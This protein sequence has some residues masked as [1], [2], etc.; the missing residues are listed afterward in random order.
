MSTLLGGNLNKQEH[1]SGRQFRP[2]TNGEAPSFQA[3]CEIEQSTG[4]IT[5][6]TETD[7]MFAERYEYSYD[8][9]GRL[10]GVNLNGQRHEVY[11]YDR[12]GRR[13][14]RLT[15]KTDTP[16]YYFYDQLGRLESVNQMTLFKYDANGNTV[17][18]NG[19]WYLQTDLLRA[20]ETCYKYG[21]NT[22]LDEAKL[23]GNIALRYEYDQKSAN[24][25]G[26]SRRFRNGELTHEY[27]WL[28]SAEGFPLLSIC[29]DISQGLEF[30]LI[31]GKRHYPERITLAR[32]PGI[33]RALDKALF[34]NGQASI[35]LRCG[36][37]QV[38]TLKRLY[39]QGREI[40]RI[41]YDSFGEV[42]NETLPMLYLPLGFAAGLTDPDTLLV[43]FG[44]RDYDPST[45]R[46]L[47]MDPAK[48]R[49]GD[50]DLYEYCMDDPVNLV[51]PKG[52]MGCAARPTVEEARQMEEQAA[53]EQGLGQR[54]AVAPRQEQPAERRWVMNQR[55]G[56]LRDPD[57]NVLESGYSGAPDYVNNP[58]AE[59][60]R[61]LGPIPRGRYR[62]GETFNSARTGPNSIRLAPEGHNA[63]DRTGLQIHGENPR[64]PPRSFSEGCP[65]YGPATR[66]R[67]TQS[68][69]QG[70]QW[71]D[72]V[73]D[74]DW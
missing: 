63:H 42:L 18:R 57:G 65:I 22:L 23:P 35:T 39:L 28:R 70:V 2:G 25:Q 66:R 9:K 11:K 30:Q 67:I 62:I 27:T 53:R 59:N 72:V 68:Q 4:K 58:D 49:R 36:C 21:D 8:P 16:E 1:A 73:G 26:P 31:Y 20:G 13:E 52:L 56:E 32:L 47:C 74:E 41:E 55:T 6:K 51:D 71:L 33:A 69:Q 40:K 14:E 3:S 38:G 44:Y 12:E 43:R 54:T 29:R 48:D 5:A 46:F 50:E 34:S 17:N 24:P 15:A 64:R 19:P 45:G 61:D 7:G 10:K 37:D 60:L